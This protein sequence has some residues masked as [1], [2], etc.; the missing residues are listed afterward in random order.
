MVDEILAA[1]VYLEGKLVR[2][3]SMRVPMLTDLGL[4]LVGSL[5]ICVQLRA[6]RLDR[7]MARVP[8]SG[9]LTVRALTLDGGHSI[10]LLCR[11]HSWGLKV[12]Y[13]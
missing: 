12:V 9:H 2:M 3:I 6:S 13:S 5:I 7:R 4:Y 10:H 11:G 1:E 8:S